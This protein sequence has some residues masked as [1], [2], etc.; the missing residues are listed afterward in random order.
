[1]LQK[2]NDF[3]APKSYVDF[4]LL[5][6]SIIRLISEAKNLTYQKVSCFCLF[7]NFFI[8]FK[9]LFIILK[10]IYYAEAFIL[11]KYYIIIK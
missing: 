8:L 9:D 5:P 4:V 2:F 7:N 10:L 6:E 11:F 3:Q 1:M